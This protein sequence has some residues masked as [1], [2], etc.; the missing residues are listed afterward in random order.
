MP[1]YNVEP[2]E[3][4]S[5][6]IDCAWY[7]GGAA[8]KESIYSTVIRYVASGGTTLPQK[9]LGAP[10]ARTYLANDI[11]LVSNFESDG[12]PGNGYNTGYND[13]A[14]AV[15]NHTTAGGPRN[16]T[17]YFSIDYDAPETDQPLINDYFKGVY[18]YMAGLYSVGV[19]GGYYVCKRLRAAYPNIKIWQTVAWSGGQILDDIEL[20]QRVG[21]ANVNGVDCDVNEIRKPGRIGAWQE[22]MDANEQVTSLIDGKSYSVSQY[23]Q[24]IDYHSF[25]TDQATAQIVTALNNVAAKLDQL[26]G[27]AA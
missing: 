16:S 27:K 23:I 13:A 21:A 17:I 4:Y 6:G 9:L 18:D 5:L 25:K 8:V 7:L 12:K 10:E 19:Y 3:I 14:L 24:F 15:R 1:N 2:G 11:A 20:Y 26:I 22:A